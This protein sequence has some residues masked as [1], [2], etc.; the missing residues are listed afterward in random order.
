[1]TWAGSPGKGISVI[2]KDMKRNVEPE[3]VARVEEL[4]LDK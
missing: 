4:G 2:A 3:R 1:M